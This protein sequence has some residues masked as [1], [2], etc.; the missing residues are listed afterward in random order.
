MRLGRALQF[1]F[2]T[3]FVLAG[4]TG[5][6]EANVDG[7]S[8]EEL[9][10]LAS[11]QIN[12]LPPLSPDPSNAFETSPAAAALGKRLFFDPQ[13][14]R[15]GKVA[16]ASC[17]DPDNQF[18]DGRP[19]GV[20]IGVAARRTMPIAGAAYNAWFFWDGRKDSLWAQALGPLEDAQEHGGNR[21]RYARLIAAHY[22]RDY[23]S[24]YGPLPSLAALPA[25]AGPFGSPAERAAWDGL[26]EA[27]RVNVSRVYANIGKAIAAFE[28][29][30]HYG[31]SRF[32]R[33]VAGVLRG[34]KS[35]GGALSA[36]EKNGLR[37]FIGKGA[38]VTCHNGPL[39]S[40][41]HFHNTGVPPRAGG[42]PDAGRAAAIAKVRQ[43]EFNCLGRYSD[44]R[45]EQC[46]ELRFLAAD[47]A[48][49]T[50]AFKT[51]S[52]RNASL[53]APYMHGGQFASLAEVVRHYALAPAAALGR[54][55]LKPFALS[56]R[57]QRD[58]VD[59]LASLAGPI[60]QRG[61]D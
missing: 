59:F 52:L 40:D 56:P 2:A 18:Q 33:Y 1:A 53:R 61:G 29:S 36:Q 3:T 14:S 26:D 12:Q 47:H 9:A 60:E 23:E 37:I 38:C 58:L 13:F 6:S 55:E 25:D 5:W 46:Q 44:A 22:R 57:E 39:L 8:A 31:E 54:S 48:A 19:L 41:Q 16:C 17:H 21:V 35:A 43:D 28:R 24:V 49:L 4:C 10:V 42:A 34:D 51:P 30:L 7:W 15:N 32:D 20:G 11:L 50:G 27:A 45:P